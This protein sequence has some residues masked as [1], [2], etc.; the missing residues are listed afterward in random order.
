M[1]AMVTRQVPDDLGGLG[2]PEASVCLHVHVLALKA[3]P[4][5]SHR[6]LNAELLARLFWLFLLGFASGTHC[7]RLD[8]CREALASELGVHFW[9]F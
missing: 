9:C 6:C 7:K 8:S 2:V 5:A 3:P 4:H 1:V